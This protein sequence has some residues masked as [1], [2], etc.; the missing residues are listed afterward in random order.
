MR[1]K[2]ELEAEIE[3]LEA[4]ISVVDENEASLQCDVESPI[5]IVN[6]LNQNS[7]ILKKPTFNLETDIDM[8]VMT[9]HVM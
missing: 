7:T 3:V 2:I 9:S 8:H 6:K 4:D 1:K 5:E